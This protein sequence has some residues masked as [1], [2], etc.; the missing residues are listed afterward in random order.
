VSFFAELRRR[1]VIRMAGL[2]LVAACLNRT[3]VACRNL[4]ERGE[5]ASP[6]VIVETRQALQQTGPE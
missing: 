6:I 4:A 5:V 1:N 2:Y 3:R